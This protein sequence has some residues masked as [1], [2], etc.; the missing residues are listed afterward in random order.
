MNSQKFIWFFLGVVILVHACNTHAERIFRC[1]PEVLVSWNISA[2]PAGWDVLGKQ[3]DRRIAHYLVSVT[4]SDGAPEG[5]A[6]LR[7]TSARE[8]PLEGGGTV[9]EKYDFSE[10]INPIIWLVCRYGNTPATLTMSI[11]A[12]LESCEVMRSKDLSEQEAR[13]H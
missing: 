13:C 1:P 8:S 9:I 12:E 10:R 4:F 11:P 2:P 3:D 7:P 6:F 5:G